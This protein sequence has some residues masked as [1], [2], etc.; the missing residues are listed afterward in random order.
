MDSS[1]KQRQ[2][3]EGLFTRLY[4]E[5]FP[6]VASYISKRGGNL[7]QAKDLFQEALVIYYEQ[8]EL[9]HK[10]V[11]KGS[12][13]YLLGVVKNLWFQQQKVSSKTSSIDL[14][15][16][17]F[18]EPITAYS[19]TQKV[20]QVLETAGKRCMDMLRAFYYEQTPLDQI[21]SQFGFGS[22]RSATVQ[23]FKCLEKVR[24]EVKEKALT[25][26]DFTD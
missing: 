9:A 17:D 5:A 22:T 1:Q 6:S 2:Q 15:K 12:K 16:T 7:D 21:A 8:V 19:S 13:A 4:L 23:K 10:P 26:A 14:L 3:R 18:P 25:Y 20:M 24:N 11:R